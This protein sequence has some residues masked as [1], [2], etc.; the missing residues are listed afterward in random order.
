MIKEKNEIKMGKKN[1]PV[2]LKMCKV[3]F[4]KNINYQKVTKEEALELHDC[5]TFLI[6]LTL[7]K[8]KKK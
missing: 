2:N 6:D 4:L 8:V 3:I 5:K 7:L 1:E